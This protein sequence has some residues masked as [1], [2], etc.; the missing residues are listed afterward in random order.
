MEFIRIKHGMDANF[1]ITDRPQ[2]MLLILYVDD[3]IPEEHLASLVIETV[4]DANLWSNQVVALQPHRIVA[5]SEQFRAT[6]GT[7][8]L[9]HTLAIPR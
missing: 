5:L 1:N 7:A 6:V 2:P 3:Y 4:S 9:L 8:D